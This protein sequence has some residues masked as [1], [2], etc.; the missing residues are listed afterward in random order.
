V[1]QKES[2]KP[3]G[4]CKLIQPVEYRIENRVKEERKGAYHY[5]DFKG[6]NKK[7]YYTDTCTDLCDYL[8]NLDPFHNLSFPYRDIRIVLKDF[9]EYKTI[10][11]TLTLAPHTVSLKHRCSIKYG[12][13]IIVSSLID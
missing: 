6:H 12:N 8:L 1:W 9:L 3:S 5:H 11:H 7:D 2:G 10:Y 13:D 4:G